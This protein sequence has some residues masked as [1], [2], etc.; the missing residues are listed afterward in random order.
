MTISIFGLGYVG[1][2]SAACFAS[3]GNDVIGVDVSLAK[4]GMINSGRSPI[5]EPGVE[6]LL[7]TAL[8]QQTLRATD[9]VDSS[10]ANSDLSFICVGTPG[11]ANGTLDL[12]QLKRVSEQIGAALRSKQKRH[13]VVVRSTVL[14][15]TT[16]DLI[17]PVIERQSGKKNSRDFDVIFN[18]E[19]LRE[20]TAIEDFEHPPFVLIGSSNNETTK[21]LAKLYDRVHAQL[22]V[23]KIKEAELVKYACNCF[24]ALKITFANEL[25]NVCKQLSIDSRR[26]SHIFCQDKQLNLSACYLRPGFA[27]GGSCLPKDLRAFLRQAS[28][29]DVDTPLLRSILVSNLLQVQKAIELIVETGR[30]QIGILGLS[31]KSGTDDLRE[32]PMVALVEALIGKGLQVSIYDREV[33]LA[34]LYGANREYIEHEIPHIAKLLKNSVK[35]V[36]DESNVLVVGKRDPEYL[37]VIDTLRDDCLL[38]DLVGLFPYVSKPRYTGLCW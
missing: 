15:G 26:V 21:Q 37:T 12:S 17:V 10:I 32:S 19:F 31:F 34:R 22:I 6:Q 33:E 1:C 8:A 11:R 2:V 35:S 7:K 30:H 24:H 20:G 16:E 27:F 14:P 25:G 28:E 29:L 38:I 3:W 23:S 13:L 36:L 5:I 4:I 9:D 18:P